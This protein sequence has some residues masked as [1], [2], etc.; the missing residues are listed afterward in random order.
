[1]TSSFFAS[2]HRTECNAHRL[3]L[4]CA[5][6]VLNSQRL[7][8]ADA[9]Q[10]TPLTYSEEATAWLKEKYAHMYRSDN[11]QE[12][13]NQLKKLVEEDNA[14]P[15]VGIFDP[16]LSLAVAHNDYEFTQSLLAHKAD[17]NEQRRFS[18]PIDQAETPEMAQL[19][20]DN[21]ADPHIENRSGNVLHSAVRTNKTTQMVAFWCTM[22]VDASLQN[23]VDSSTPL[24]ALFLSTLNSDENES[25]AKKH[26]A[27]NTAALLWSGADVNR[28][29][30]PGKN[31]LQLL[32]SLS[33]ELAPSMQARM[34]I[35]PQVKQEKEQEYAQGIMQTVAPLVRSEDV[36]KIV[37]TLMGPLVPLSW[38][39]HYMPEIERRVREKM[40]V[41]MPEAS[42]KAS[43][44]LRSPSQD[45]TRKH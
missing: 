29:N 8:S 24:H 6:L 13:R 15:N 7:Y 27:E 43:K 37:I 44:R 14:D 18:Y 41:A 33:P 45:R 3:V 10:P 1:M 25:N 21:K 28:K 23:K 9:P 19:L 36:A 16:L 12:Y 31:P 35:V 42:R 5:W 11:Y 40:I 39:P 20:I 32:R 4:I 34:T 26:L 30:R 2:H 22:G 17:P 38:D